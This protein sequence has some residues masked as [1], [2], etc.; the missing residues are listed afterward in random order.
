MITALVQFKLPAPLTRD[1]AQE[2]FSSTAP[3]YRDFQGLIRKYYVLS[4]DG[5]TAGGV[6]LWQSRADAERLYTDEWKKFIVEKYGSEP[7]I[8]Y[9]ESP[10]I[11]DNLTGE[12]LKDA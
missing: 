6:Y 12:I 3:R 1:E 7:F 4:E 11:V 10:I 8:T 5:G 9:F 2:I